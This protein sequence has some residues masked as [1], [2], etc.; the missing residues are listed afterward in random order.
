MF[1]KKNRMNPNM[2]NQPYNPSYNPYIT[3]IMIYLFWKLK[4]MN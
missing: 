4:L 3:V 1:S 2:Y